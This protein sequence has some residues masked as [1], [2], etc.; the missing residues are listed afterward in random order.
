VDDLPRRDGQSAVEI[1]NLSRGVVASGG[2]AD[3]KCGQSAILERTVR[4]I[5]LK[6]S[7]EVVGSGGSAALNR[8]RSATW[9]RTV[10]R[11]FQFEV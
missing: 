5:D 2:F 3:L 10:R 7:R 9:V 8:G 11:A 6:L 4:L 1:K